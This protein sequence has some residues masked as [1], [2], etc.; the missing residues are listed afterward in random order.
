MALS[1]DDLLKFT[2]ESALLFKTKNK[3]VDTLDSEQSVSSEDT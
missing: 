1:Y 3:Q 2:D